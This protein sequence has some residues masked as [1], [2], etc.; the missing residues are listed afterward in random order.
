[1]LGGCSDSL[2]GQRLACMM[3]CFG[4]PL[5]QTRAKAIRK[6]VDKMIQLAKD[7]SLHA[8]RQVRPARMRHRQCTRL[9]PF[10]ASV[11]A[12]GKPFFGLCCA[13]LRAG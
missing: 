1:M 8:R 12:W 3:M 5:A 4:L 11:V 7:G 13:W 2:T 9:L 10:H 6:H